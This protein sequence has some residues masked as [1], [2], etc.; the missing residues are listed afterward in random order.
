[1]SL[2]AFSQES[3]DFYHRS[4]GPVFITTIVISRWGYTKGLHGQII[5]SMRTLMTAS[6]MFCTDLCTTHVCPCTTT[7]ST[8]QIQSVSICHRFAS[9]AYCCSPFCCSG[10]WLTL[11]NIVIINHSTTKKKHHH[12]HRFHW[13]PLYLCLHSLPAIISQR[14]NMPHIRLI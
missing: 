11:S 5:D 13:N 10:C 8:L 14:H 7:S 4:L 3:K 1:M 2:C 9:C 6:R 12:H